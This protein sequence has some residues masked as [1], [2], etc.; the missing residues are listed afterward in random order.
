MKKVELLAPARNAEI[1][2]EAFKHGADAVYIG[3]GAFSA[4]AAAGNSID[5]IERLAAFGHQYHAKTI[6]AFNTI[7]KNE[8]MEQAERLAW[9]LYEAG[10]DALII[11]DLGLLQ[12]NLPPIELHASTQTDNRTIEKV[13]L[14]HELGMKRVVMARELSVQKIREIHEALPDVELECF[15]H[16]AL[17]VC[18]SGQCYLSQSMTGRS[19][20]RGECAQPCRL[21]MDLTDAEGRV[22]A[23]Q[24]HLLSLRDMNRSEYLRQ[25]IDAGVYSLKIEGRLKDAEY[26]KNVVA[27]YRQLIDQMEGVANASLGQCTYTFEPN[28]E[29]AFNRG[30]T[31]FFADG[32]RRP[33]WNFETPKSIGEYIGNI[34]TVGR[35]YFTIQVLKASQPQDLK[36]S[37]PV[38]LNN[39]DGLA[40]GAVGFRLNRYDKETG[41]CYPLNGQEVCRQLRKGQQVRRNLDVAFEQTLSK[42]S[43]NRRIPVSLTCAVSNSSLT[44]TARLQE[45]PELVVEETLN[46]NFEAAKIPQH[47][48]IC[49]QLSKLG[50]TIF[51]LY[52]EIQVIGDA[53]IPSSMLSLLRRNV[54]NRLQQMLLQQ[55]ADNRLSFQK[56]DY[57]AL[58]KE[59]DANGILPTDYHANVL[60]D[61][62]REMFSLMKINH[63]ESAFES[64][65][66]KEGVVMTSRHCLKYAFGKCPK[67]RNPQPEP[68]PQ[69]MDKWRE[70]LT[71]QIGKRKFILNFGCQNDCMS[72]IFTIFAPKS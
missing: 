70:P 61:Q 10:A 17:C 58:A 27:Y 28:V 50:D 55:Q 37:Q 51:S 35:D 22:I 48:N 44:L 69:G 18:V 6:V 8:E 40:C 72:K 66:N 2:I 12:L 7:L 38:S 57:V 20:N 43:A 60:N 41:R 54:C 21:P 24:K 25:L 56:P 45:M 39:G 9:Q 46:G 14:L 67:F 65:N 71:L 29:K 1:G 26:V 68:L 53:F 13:R 3:A 31:P 4:R 34:A 30:F 42:P 16:G 19:A 5:D 49:K 59:I 33:M 47:D 63:V 36:T 52:G 15:V 32:E 11:Q 64:Q 23:R 62:A